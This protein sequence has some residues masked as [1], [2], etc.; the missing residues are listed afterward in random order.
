MNRTQDFPPGNKRS[1]TSAV[2]LDRHRLVR[3]C[4]IM[5]AILLGTGLALSA[6]A[7]HM[8]LAE[9]PTQTF[10]TTQGEEVTVPVVEQTAVDDATVPDGQDA[11]PQGDGDA[12]AAES[13]DD[14]TITLNY[15]EI[16][17]YEDPD[18]E[19]DE[20]RTR[21]MGT[22]T[23]S[24]FHEGQSVSAWD[25]VVDIP[26]FFFWDGWP[27]N[28][29]VSKDPNQNVFTFN[30]MR[31]WNSEYTVNYYVMTGAD[32]TADT[33]AGALAP[34]DVTFTK[35]GSEVFTN[36]RFDKLIK[37]DAYEYKLDGMYVIDTYPAQIRLG[38][39][40]DNNVIN[41]LYTPDAATLPDDLE[42]PD[43]IFDHDD[44]VTTL[45]DSVEVPDDIFDY[46]DIIATLPD[47]LEVPDDIFNYDDLITNLPDDVI[48]EDF[49]GTD[50]DGTD[51]DVIIEITDE[52]LDNPVPKVDAEATI[53]AYRTGMEDG[54]TVAKTGDA[55]FIAVSVLAGVALVAAVVFGVI[56]WRN[57]KRPNEADAS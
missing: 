44:L 6:Y 51:E 15:Y 55:T 21:L 34:E 25:Y 37:G 17:N 40:P 56:A 29:T 11:Q 31:L 9:G 33:W 53:N 23:L 20:N 46:N 22:R 10:V 48:V 3:I 14:C 47:D 41:V 8:A 36:Q 30:Y 49:V 13:A 4:A 2:A 57:R 45:P 50:D 1:G 28:I 32:L 19:Y 54:K 16:V 38:T 42:I 18:I 7:V 5:A 39:D 43:G 27:N 26:G 52:M 35:L 24:G 12:T